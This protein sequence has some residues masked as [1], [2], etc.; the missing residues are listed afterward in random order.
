MPPP[1][2]SFLFYCTQLTIFDSCQ[3]RK[4]IMYDTLSEGKG[5]NNNTNSIMF[6]DEMRAVRTRISLL[7]RYVRMIYDNNIGT[8]THACMSSG[9]ASSHHVFFD[10]QQQHTAHPHHHVY[11]SASASCCLPYCC[12]YLLEFHFGIFDHQWHSS[13]TQH[14]H[15]IKIESH[16]QYE[17][18]LLPPLVPQPVV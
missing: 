13:S 6:S 18:S 10:Q 4:V 8:S 3:A 9:Q 2:K 11:R 12:T 1:Q 17:R 14:T 16:E 15:K 7:L 5:S